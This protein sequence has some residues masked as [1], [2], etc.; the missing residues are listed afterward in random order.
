MCST[1]PIENVESLKRYLEDVPLP[2]KSVD[3]VISN[4]VINLSGDH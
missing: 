3:V 1:Q 4:R 2:T